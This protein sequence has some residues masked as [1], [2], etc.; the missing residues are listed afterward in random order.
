MSIEAAETLLTLP[1]TQIYLRHTNK[2]HTIIPEEMRNTFDILK[3]EILFL[4]KEITEMNTIMK[5]QKERIID[6][7]HKYNYSTY[8]LNQ[9]TITINKQNQQIQ[10][11]LMK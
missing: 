2:T 3:K 6:L 5:K 8:L 7:E 11:S 10:Q 1:Q 4:H 9:Q